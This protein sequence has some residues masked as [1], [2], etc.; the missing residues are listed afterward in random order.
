MVRKLE[1]ERLEAWCASVAERGIESVCEKWYTVRVPVVPR[2]LSSDRRD[3]N[4]NPKVP[5]ESQTLSQ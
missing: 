4:P 2:F 1:G 3:P 5:Y